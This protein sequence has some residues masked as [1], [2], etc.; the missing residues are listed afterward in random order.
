MHQ[1]NTPAGLIHAFLLD[2]Q[3][4]GRYLNWDEVQQWTADS[5]RLWLHF[6]YT[7]A[8]AINWINN[9][10]GLDD[11]ITEALLTEETRPRAVS[12]GDGL[13]M[14][15]RG[16]N[17]NPDSDPEDMVSLRIWV[18]DN[19]IISTRK[20]TLI[21]VQD[22]LNQL[23]AGK[24]PVN[25]AEFVVN[26][27]DRL[28][29]RMGD[30]VD[31][32]EDRIGELEDNA[33]SEDR[34]TLRFDLATLRRQTITLRRYLAPQREAFSR[35][36][37]E[38]VSWFDDNDRMRMR[39]VSDRLI[40]HIEDIDAVRERAAVTHE[41]LISR[42]SEQLNERMYVLSIVAAVFLPLGF[43]T[44]LLGINV[45]GIPGAENPQAFLVFS[46]ILIIVVIM[47]IA[48]FKWKKWL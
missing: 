31:Q 41:E 27:A 25:S 17:K 29:W 40:R 15:L 2:G 3:G 1:P 9:Q 28:V 11:L 7:E 45:G 35:L 30:T 34:S 19:R 38:K 8:F 47:Q 39:E 5:G 44:G 23:Q 10:S 43:F 18:D 26:L 22:L 16:V 33:L 24:G 21:S 48:F 6:D 42:M 4:S 12:I 36:M 14:A 32:F 20:R 37:V 13:L 46:A